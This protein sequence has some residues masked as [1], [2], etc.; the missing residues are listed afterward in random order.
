MGFTLVELLIV[1]SV[2]AMLS[3]LL[4]SGAMAVLSASKVSRTKLLLATV[5]TACRQFQQDV[6]A[7]PRGASLDAPL[8][9]QANGDIMVDPATGLPVPDNDAVW[10]SGASLWNVGNGLFAR[11]GKR[12]P[13]DRQETAIAN[14]ETMRRIEMERF[15][16][17]GDFGNMGCTGLDKPGSWTLCPTMR[18]TG[19]PVVREWSF[20]DPFGPTTYGE[21]EL[22]R[23]YDHFRFSPARFRST[24]EEGNANTR[25]WSAFSIFIVQ[26]FQRHLAF[27]R[28]RDAAD[29]YK[30]ALRNGVKAQS[31]TFDSGFDDDSVASSN[32]RTL[33]TRTLSISTGSGPWS[34]EYLVDLEDRH[35]ADVD[36]DGLEDI[37]DAWGRPLVYI[38]EGLPAA[39]RITSREFSVVW[40]AYQVY[41]SSGGTHAW[42]SML[43]YHPDPDLEPNPDFFNSDWKDR[44]FWITDKPNGRGV[45]VRADAA[46]ISLIRH[47]FA[48]PQIYARYGYDPYVCGDPYSL[49]GT[50]IPSRIGTRDQPTNAQAGDPYYLLSEDGSSL[51]E[52][53]NDLDGNGV[54]DTNEPY[55]DRDR[56]GS[57]SSSVADNDIRLVAPM[58][59]ERGFDLLSAGRDLRFHAVR[60][61]RAN[62]DNIV[63][64]VGK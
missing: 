28:P 20:Y 50:V 14:A 62:G 13:R 64:R 19:S 17:I 34:G 63:H 16:H 4:L 6:R 2:I 55:I 11:L 31:I 1:L 40:S 36:G 46:D 25:H 59:T 57:Y 18:T 58:G 52:P 61:H 30:V 26:N 27:A 24:G 10:T 53:F 44:F 48:H 38:N 45:P 41:Q 29:A 51:R 5:D 49:A 12:M 9:Y 33:Y 37:L 43:R 3:S 56:N 39:E 54:R 21:R 8:R 32:G 23:I 15:Y 47:G 42:Q 35:H 7:F 22:K 60:T